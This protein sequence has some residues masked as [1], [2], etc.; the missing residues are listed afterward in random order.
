[1]LSVGCDASKQ[2]ESWRVVKH[3]YT[4]LMGVWVYKDMVIIPRDTMKNY[5]SSYIQLH[6][7]AKQMQKET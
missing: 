3:L 7:Y 4:G 6:I 2:W 1:M 5:D